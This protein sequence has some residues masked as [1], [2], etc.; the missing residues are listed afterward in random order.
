MVVDVAIHGAG[1]VKLLCSL[2]EV[3]NHVRSGGKLRY[4]ECPCG[5]WIVR[6]IH[7]REISAY[8]SDLNV[9]IY[10]FCALSRM[11]ERDS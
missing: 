6:S 7:S 4:L 9:S 5:F 3:V 10:L 8:D 11:I 2:H 1:E